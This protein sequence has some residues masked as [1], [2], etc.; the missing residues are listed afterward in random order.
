MKHFE[1]PRR[2]DAID[3]FVGRKTKSWFLMASLL[4][5]KDNSIG[6]G[7]GLHRASPFSNQV[8]CIWYLYDVTTENDPFQSFPETRFKPM[9]TRKDYPLG[10]SRFDSVSHELVEAKAGSLLACDTKGIYSGKPIK[11]GVRYAVTHKRWRPMALPPICSVSV[12]STGPWRNLRPVATNMGH[13]V[14][15]EYHREC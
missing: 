12:R 9:K 14:G 15:V 2:I 7:G 1:V 6:S 8:K 5:P 3:A 11:K 10:E 13:V 4:L